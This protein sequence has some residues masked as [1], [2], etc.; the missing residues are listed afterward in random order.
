MGGGA[1][2]KCGQMQTRGEWGRGGKKTWAKIKFF[3]CFWQRGVSASRSFLTDQK[4]LLLAEVIKF[5]NPENTGNY[6]T[7][8]N[9]KRVFPKMD[10]FGISKSIFSYI[11]WD[12]C[13]KLGSYVLGTKTKLSSDQNF[14]LGLKSENIE[15]WKLLVAQNLQKWA[16]A[17]FKIEYCHFWDLNQNS[18]H[19]K[20]LF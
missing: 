5:W 10:I 16:L 19:L 1:E 14:D 3:C 12:K 9:F 13:L 17:I 8:A 20:V 18:G 2:G 6:S 7:R 15:F 4:I 11:F